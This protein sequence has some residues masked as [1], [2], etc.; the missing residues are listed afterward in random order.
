MFHFPIAMPGFESYTKWTA[1]RLLPVGKGE[2]VDR[3]QNAYVVMEF[4]GEMELV[5]RSNGTGHPIRF[6][7]KNSD[8][9]HTADNIFALRSKILNA[10]PF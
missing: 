4:G 5:A 7:V 2:V 1:P 6:K 10:V 3:P 8:K 9:E